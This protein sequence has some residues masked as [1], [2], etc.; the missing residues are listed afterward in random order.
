MQVFLQKTTSFTLETKKKG[1]YPQN[2]SINAFFMAANSF[3]EISFSIDVPTRWY[4]KSCD[5][6]L[7]PS[8]KSDSS[9]QFNLHAAK[10]AVPVPYM[11][12]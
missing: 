6:L 11:Y 7:L 3:K 1:L 9:L 8:L 5:V 12:K 10:Q 4:T 2:A